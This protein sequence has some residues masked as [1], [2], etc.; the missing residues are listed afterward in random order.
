MS[1]KQSVTRS[2]EEH[3]ASLGALTAAITH[4]VNNPLFAIIGFAQLGR[5]ASTLAEAQQY[6]ALI[7]RDA[8]RANELLRNVLDLARAPER[9]LTVLALNDVVSST[10]AACRHHLELAGA[11]VET[12]LAQALPPVLS[13]DG[14]LRQV[15]VNLLLN[16][17]QAVQDAPVKRI[18]VETAALAAGEGCLVRVSD[19]GAGASTKMPGRLATFSVSR[20]LLE[21]L[22]GKLELD[23]TQAQGTSLLLTLPTGRLERGL[24][25]PAG[26][27]HHRAVAPE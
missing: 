16:A 4:E 7:E 23:E 8:R 13:N 15:L 6:L 10:V 9:G 2:H 18:T 27:A 21:E 22:G 11:S 5:S 1:K 3:L 26:R 19:T 17:G 24:S 25:P 12:R 14:H 20:H